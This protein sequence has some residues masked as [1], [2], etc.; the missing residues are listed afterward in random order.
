[1]PP[2]HFIPQRYHHTHPLNAL[3]DATIEYHPDPTPSSLEVSLSLP[4]DTPTV[5]Q[6][7]FQVINGALIYTLCSDERFLVFGGIF[8]A[9]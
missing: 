8:V 6:T 7:L 2:H 4:Q 3:V 9:A 1:M 5:C